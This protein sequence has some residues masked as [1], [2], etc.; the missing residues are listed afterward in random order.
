MAEIDNLSVF[1]NQGIACSGADLLQQAFQDVVDDEKRDNEFVAFF[2]DDGG[3]HQTFRLTHEQAAALGLTFEVDSFNEEKSSVISQPQSEEHLNDILEEESQIDDIEFPADSEWIQDPGDFEYH[4]NPIEIEEEKFSQVMSYREEDMPNRSARSLVLQNHQN[5]KM[6]NRRLTQNIQETPGAVQRP[7]A[8]LTQSQFMMKPVPTV[9]KTGKTFRLVSNTNKSL[10]SNASGWTCPSQ[11]SVIMNSIQKTSAM[12][13]SHQ[14]SRNGTI[15]TQMVNGVNGQLRLP[16][17]V[18]TGQNI[19]NVQNIQRHQQFY[20]VKTSETVRNVTPQGMNGKTSRSLVKSVPISTQIVRTSVLPEKIATNS[21]GGNS[22][23]VFKTTTTRVNTQDLKT[24]NNVNVRPQNQLSILKPQKTVVTNG[25]KPNGISATKIIKKITISPQIPSGEGGTVQNNNSNNLQ[26]NF[27]N[28]D[29]KAVVINEAKGLTK[30]EITERPVPPLV[31]SVPV[32]DKSANGLE[33]PI[34]IVQQGHTFHS[35]Q[36]LTQTQLKQIAQV[37]QQRGQQES[38][39]SKEKVVYRVVFPEELDLRIRNPGNLLKTGRG[40]RGRPKKAPGRHVAAVKVGMTDEENDELKEDRKKVVARTRSGRLSRPPRHMVRDYKHLHPLDFMQPDLDDSDGGYSD[41]NTNTINPQI[42]GEETKVLLTGLELPKRKVSTH[43]RCST[44]N[45]MYL[46]RARL[47][48]HF[49]LFPEHGSIELLPS[50]TLTS[51]GCAE[52]HK[53]S[54]P[55]TVDSFKRKGKKRGPWAYATPEAKSERRQTKL[56]EALSVCDSGEISK[57]AAKPVLNAQSLFDLMAIK[58]DNNVKLF[59]TEL[60]VF[61][62]KIREQAGIMLSPVVDGDKEQNLIELRDELLCDALGLVPGLYSVNDDVFKK[63]EPY[64]NLDMAVPEEPPLKLQKLRN[65]EGK[66]NIEERL[67]SGFSESSD[68][69]VSDFLTERKQDP[70]CPEV[71]T[72]LTLMPRNSSPV[73]ETIKNSVSKLLISS[74]QIQKQISDNPGFQKVDINSSK[75]PTFKKN[76]ENGLDIFDQKVESQGFIKLEPMQQNF[77]KL[78]NN[79]VGTL[80]NDFEDLDDGQNF[81]KGFQKIIC[82]KPEGL[83]GDKSNCKIPESLPILQDTVPIMNANC[84]ASIFGGTDN[85]DPIGH[86]D[87]SAVMDKHLMMDE[88]LVEQLHLVD[89]SNLVDELVSERLKNIIPDNILENN[90]MPNTTNLDTELD[91]EALS[92]EF[93]RNTRS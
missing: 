63:P 87:Y 58:S 81:T 29:T 37:L 49:E 69:S 50:S 43:F 66:E 9:L 20:S 90:L 39:G 1:T 84:D 57:I 45:K 65:D 68:L 79:T 14:G 24:I 92:E 85:L 89:Q 86:L 42:E 55:L 36:K 75:S 93:N 38:P 70:N 12:N 22:Q 88:K 13:G 78:E 17:L 16:P 64:H 18:K 74:P 56:R 30:G 40:K 44:C 5:L 60:K 73:A 33:N 62:E 53:K 52:E 72:A 3:Q 59:L 21:K 2:K 31:P 61:M 71:L 91:F 76:E 19:H 8:P 54:P 6:L 11:N 15:N 27:M 48:K 4:D 34:Q 41:Y 46:G 82:D 51:N 83:N 77:I 67:S 10:I 80:E 25:N 23:V 28:N 7:P 26:G 32:E 47:A 35:N